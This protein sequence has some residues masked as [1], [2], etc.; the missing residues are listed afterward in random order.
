MALAAGCVYFLIVFA[1]GFALGTLRVLLIA[2]RVGEMAAVALE[3]PAMLAASWFAAGWVAR[4]FAVP[5]RLAPRLA[6]GAIAFA[7]LML[8]EFALAATMGRSPAA[9]AAALLTAPGLLGL[10]GQIAFALCP[11]ARI[12]GRTAP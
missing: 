10:A 8:A 12:C 4:R 3:L 9:F 7:V 1:A 6:M 11:A 2:P 5:A